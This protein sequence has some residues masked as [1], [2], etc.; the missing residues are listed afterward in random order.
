MTGPPSR[1]RELGRWRPELTVSVVIPAYQ[2]QASL[3]LTLAALAG[4]TYPAE[5]LEVVVVD[6]D[7]DPTLELPP[8]A[9]GTVP[10]RPPTV[11][12]GAG[13]CAALRR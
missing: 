6:D 3:D 12:L 10:D 11:R 4:Q 5:L 13:Q 9:A 7:S 1:Y 2:C 8:S